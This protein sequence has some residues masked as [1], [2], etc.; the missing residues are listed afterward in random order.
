M[1]LVP[2]AAAACLV[3]LA[4]CAGA[5]A[6]LKPQPTTV[7]ASGAYYCWKNRLNDDGSNLVCNWESSP[8]DA[9]ESNAV[10]SLAKSNV[11]GTPQSSRHCENGQWLVTVTSR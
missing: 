8:R 5:P 7:A 11:S 2:V 4:G 6:L 9:C 10:V 1:K 3:A